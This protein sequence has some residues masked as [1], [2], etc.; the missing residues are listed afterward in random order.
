MSEKPPTWFENRRRERRDVIDSRKVIVQ[1]ARHENLGQDFPFAAPQSLDSLERRAIVVS[2]SRQIDGYIPPDRMN[3]DNADDLGEI[4][5][6]GALV[7]LSDAPFAC[8]SQELSEVIAANGD[9]ELARGRVELHLHRRGDAWIENQ[10]PLKLDVLQDAGSRSE[11]LASRRERHFDISRPRK[12]DQIADPM[13][14]QIAQVRRI[15][16]HFP[17][18]LG[19][20]EPDS[21]QRMDRSA[22][23]DATG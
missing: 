11:N 4:E 7:D 17:G 16:V 19:N 18:R 14:R 6:T 3:R 22:H 2:G 9:S 8:T 13:V 20:L 21:Q 23:A 10:E 15:Q 12:N 5:L 1:A